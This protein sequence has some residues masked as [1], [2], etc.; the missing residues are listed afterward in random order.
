MKYALIPVA[1]FCAQFSAFGQAQDFQLLKITSNF[2]S[3]P[4]FTYTGAEQY[5]ADQRQRW[6][7]IEVLLAARPEF[8]DELTVKYFVLFNG[9]LLTGEVSHT[10]IP[11]GREDRSVIYVTP[12][13]LQ[14]LMLGRPVTNA[15]LQNVAVQIV[16]QGM[17]RDELSL[18]P[19]AAGW[20][21]GLPQIPGLMVNK[22][23]TPFAP[24]Y[25]DRYLEIK[26][27]R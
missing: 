19:A 18:T 15:A 13:T 2:I 6:L 8:S 16:Q 3:S 26:A 23:E 25:W 7:E 27:P 10:N 20:Y 12:K 21:V 5:I 4:Q 14:R 11:A 1:L 9:K 17:I 22:N 24:L